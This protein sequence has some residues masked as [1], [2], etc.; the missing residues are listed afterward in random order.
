MEMYS[1]ATAPYKGQN[2]KPYGIIAVEYRRTRFR[3][4]FFSIL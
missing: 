2:K 1:V 3:N 4:T